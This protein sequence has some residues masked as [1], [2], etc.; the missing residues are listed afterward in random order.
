[1][2]CSKCQKL[3]DDAA[4]GL[5][6]EALSR[7][8]HEHLASCP[9]CS[10]VWQENGA[11]RLVL[12][13]AATPPLVPEAA[14]YVRL[15]RGA[16]ARV[17][18]EQSTTSPAK[19]RLLDALPGWLRRARLNPLKLANAAVFLA[20]G[21][22]FG[23]GLS[24]GLHSGTPEQPTRPGIELV[25][26]STPTRAVE[27]PLPPEVILRGIAPRPTLVPGEGGV[28]AT[29][30]TKIDEPR[31]AAL[32]PLLV[33]P[34]LVLKAWQQTVGLLDKLGPSEEVEQLRQV[35]RL[36]RRVEAATVLTRLQDLKLQL[37]RGGQTEY[38]PVV[39][40]VEEVFNE[41]A[42][43]SPETQEAHFAQL[44]T[45]QEAERALIEKRYDEAMRLFKMVVLQ[46][47]GSYLAARAMYQM[48]N[49]NFEYFR[50]YKNALLDYS[51][52]L[53]E[54]PPHF[55]SQTIQDQIHERVELITQNTVDKYAPLRVFYQAQSAAEPV[56][57]LALYTSLLARYPQSPLA[58][59]AIEAMTRAVRQA[60]DDDVLVNRA[61]ETLVQFQEQN[62]DHPFEL[63]AQ[64][65]VADI[66]HYCLRNHS[67]AALEY[68]KVLEKA[69]DPGM[70]ETVRA[71]LRLLGRD[72]G[73]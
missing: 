65:G 70:I 45:Y 28:E 71:R 44:D 62:R 58:G 69:K 43:V 21:V 40:R 53:N 8:V 73:E 51:Q 60:A 47:P 20:I 7:K 18:T 36:S 14:Y 34:E 66:T 25:Q 38:I 33:D 68:S 37:V 57:A 55:L 15:A 16:M 50:D 5:L 9:A 63:N 6:S 46:A 39:H 72:R 30:I 32:E 48:G 10:V 42:A 61:L 67:Q 22:L 41:L 35:Q 49:I 4:R 11:L 64:L 59:Q 1:M 24:R 23:F 3:Y 12:R 13:E 56:Q 27:Q 26:R 19:P 52:C 31:A 29:R 17:E 2:R 54:S